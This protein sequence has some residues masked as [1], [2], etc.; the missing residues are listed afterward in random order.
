[1]PRKNMTMDDVIE[2]AAAQDDGW[3]D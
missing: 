1:V 2:A 3:E